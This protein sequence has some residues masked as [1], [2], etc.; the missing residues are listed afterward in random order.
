MEVQNPLPTIPLKIST[1]LDIGQGQ[2]LQ[3]E[4]Q[5]ELVDFLGSLGDLFLTVAKQSICCVHVSGTVAQ[6]IKYVSES[7]NAVLG[8]G[9]LRGP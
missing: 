7:H 4:D 5:G 8:S 1:S 2:A 6:V 3:A 9:C